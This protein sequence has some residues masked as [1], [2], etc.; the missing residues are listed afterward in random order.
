MSYFVKVNKK[1][2]FKRPIVQAELA[3]RILRQPS[4]YDAFG[5]NTI[6]TLQKLISKDPSIILTFF[7]Q[8]YGIQLTKSILSTPNTSPDISKILVSK[9]PGN[10][11]VSIIN[12]MS[13][14]M[15]FNPLTDPVVPIQIALVAESAI[16]TFNGINIR[17][18]A[19][20]TST[21]IEI[22]DVTGFSISVVGNQLIEMNF[23]S[24]TWN[25]THPQQVPVLAVRPES[26]LIIYFNTVA[27]TKKFI[28]INTF[29][30]LETE[31]IRK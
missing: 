4:Y 17:Y 5:N 6:Q 9:T 30:Q 13:L 23:F 18:Q 7:D 12:D 1:E 27:Q 24:L 11:P 19:D 16:E 15:G 14:A 25:Q 28:Q 20:K 10:Q 3:N 22:T 29:V 26:S 2:S 21:Q 8:Y 31:I